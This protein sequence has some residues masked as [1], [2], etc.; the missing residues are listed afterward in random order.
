MILLHFFTNFIN[1]LR[2]SFSGKDY[3][4]EINECNS[5]GLPSFFSS[6]L[7]CEIDE[8]YIGYSKTGK[9]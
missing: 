4:R 3:T 8:A 5:C 7:K 2:K 9:L 6:C 1:G